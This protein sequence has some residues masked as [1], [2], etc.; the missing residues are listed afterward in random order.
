MAR[1]PDFNLSAWRTADSTGREIV[2]KGK[3][4]AAWVNDDGTIDISLNTC[5][6]LSAA[7]G[8][9][10]TLY[11]NDDSYIPKKKKKTTEPVATGPHNDGSPF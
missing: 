8:F 4:G 7:D 6:V 5:V 1:S 2:Q 3:V 10:L 9:K 11:P